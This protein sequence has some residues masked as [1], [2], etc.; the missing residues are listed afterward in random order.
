M[1]GCSKCK[2]T[3]FSGTVTKSAEISIQKD[4]E[5]NLIP[6]LESEQEIQDINIEMCSSCGVEILDP[7]KDLIALFI[8]KECNNNLSLDE[9]SDEENLCNIC[10]NP[11]QDLIGLLEADYIR[12]IVELERQLKEQKSE[13][14]KTKKKRKPRKKKEEETKEAIFDPTAI[15]ELTEDALSDLTDVSS[16]E[17]ITEELNEGIS[18]DTNEE[19]SDEIVGGIINDDIIM[20]IDDDEMPPF[21]IEDDE[22]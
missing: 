16:E 15:E 19:L 20:P 12:K 17:Q 22:I 6:I 9:M 2:G 5:G 10:S 14:K 18:N 4:E 21:D 8:C 3:V 7:S 1:I 11:R 13:E